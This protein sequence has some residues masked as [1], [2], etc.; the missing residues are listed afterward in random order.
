MPWDCP[1]IDHGV[2][3]FPN[4][5]IRPC[6]QASADYSKPLSSIRDP[7]RFAD[8]KS[9]D[10]P[11]ACRTCW[12]N[13]DRGL[14][15]YRQFFLSKSL[16]HAQGIVFLDFRHSNQCNLKCRFCH[17]HFSN[18]WG[19]ELAYKIP[20]QKSDINLYLDDLLSENLLDMYWCGGEPLLMKDHYDV[21]IKSINLG[22]SDKINL[23]YNTN[24]MLLHYKDIDVVQLWEKFKTVSIV[25]SIEAVGKPLSFIRSGS[26][27]DVIKSN[28]EKLIEIRTNNSNI[29]IILAPTVSM[30]NVWFLP[31]LYEYANNNNLIVQPGILRGPDYLS[32][33]AVHPRLQQAAKEKIDIIK[34]FL[35]EANYRS[36]MH[37]LTRDDNEYLFLHAIRHILLLDK[38]RGE[39]LF[40]F[41]PYKDLAIE[42]TVKNHEY[43]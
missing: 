39:N 25:V 15:S 34:S 36:M 11:E 24:L 18:Q 33:D 42:L 12:E 8:L 32:L 19:K 20:L 16:A 1:A 21:L 13:E 2:A 28:I 43:E 14:T 23:R 4:Q 29:Q 17:P 27:W 26:E 22:L 37:M 9:S 35:S 3:I 41:L 31:E 7:N 5:K 38:I 40:D 30:L 10:R 6:C